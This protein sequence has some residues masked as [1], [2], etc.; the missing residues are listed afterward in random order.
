MESFENKKANVSL[1]LES[2]SEADIDTLLELEKS[3]SGSNTY[4]PNLER[5]DWQEEFENGK[6]FL[7]KDGDEVV[8]NISYQ[9]KG[10]D[11]LYISGLVVRPEF[12]GKG[13]GR[14][15]LQQVLDTYPEATRVDLVTH[16]DNPALKLYESL[17]FIVESRKENYWGDGEPRL[18]LVLHRREGK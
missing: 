6:V 18:V 7:I 4:S 13:L 9:E 5:E 11:H 15:A 17:G 8:G 3:V 2:A 1:I 16:P 12:Q 10:P 14:Q